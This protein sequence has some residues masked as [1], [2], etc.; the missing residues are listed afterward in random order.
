MRTP[1]LLLIILLHVL[2]CCVIILDIFLGLA[3]MLI[4]FM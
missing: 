3:I 2:A 1:F 4:M